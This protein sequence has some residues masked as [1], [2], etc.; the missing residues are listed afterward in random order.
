MSKSCF[1]IL[2]FI[3]SSVIAQIYKWTDSHQVIHYSD[4]PH[5][6]AS[7]VNLPPLQIYKTATA[8]EKRK[9]K[10]KSID[11]RLKY[12]FLTIVQP[13][14]NQTIYS[15]AGQ[16]IIFLVIKPTLARGH[17]IELILDGMPIGKPQIKPIF[18]LNSIDR[19]A[20]TLS[21]QI[22]D[23]FEKVLIR[24]K[25]IRVYVHRTFKKKKGIEL[26]QSNEI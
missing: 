25:T 1:I 11:K 6:N 22:I 16:L 23:A 21:V 20:H 8:W 17:R 24:S 9:Q 10:N 4:Q 2:L 7:I 5:Q 13:L 3:S 14:D 12:D 26:I 19:G 15:N 18:Q